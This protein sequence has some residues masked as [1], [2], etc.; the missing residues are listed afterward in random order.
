MRLPARIFKRPVTLG[1][2][3]TAS[4]FQIGAC[5]QDSGVIFQSQILYRPDIEQQVLICF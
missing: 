4:H 5:A 3:K 1:L 2:Y